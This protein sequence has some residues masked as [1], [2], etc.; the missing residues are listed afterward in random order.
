MICPTG[1]IITNKSKLRPEIEKK[2]ELQL[3]VEYIMYFFVYWGV[4]QYSEQKKQSS[5]RH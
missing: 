3:Q 5:T 2:K 1:T 4:N